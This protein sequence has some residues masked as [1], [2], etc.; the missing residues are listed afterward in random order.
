MWTEG[1]GDQSTDH[2]IR[3]Y[4]PEPQLGDK[5]EGDTL[6]TVI[7]ADPSVHL[8]TAVCMNHGEVTIPYN[9]CDT[10][11]I[12]YGSDTGTSKKY[13]LYITYTLY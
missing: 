2:L 5:R 6:L 3:L 10:Y 11:N 12:Y 1:V 7:E 8:L 9:K 4:P 13:N